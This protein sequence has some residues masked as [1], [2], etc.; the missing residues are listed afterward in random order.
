MRGCSSSAPVLFRRLQAEAKLSQGGGRF[1][2]NEAAVFGPIDLFVKRCKKLIELFT[3]IHQFSTLAQVHYTLSHCTSVH[4]VCSCPSKAQR[5]AL[6]VCIASDTCSPSV[7]HMCAGEM[8]KLKIHDHAAK[9]Y[10]QGLPST[11]S[12]LYAEHAHRGAGGADVQSLATSWRRSAASL[13]ICWTPPRPSLS[14][15][16]WSSTCTSAIWRPPSRRRPI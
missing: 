16:S 6:G 3:T 5:H 2:A 15:T 9:L 11:L 1:E 12:F 13:T 7:L 4:I 14:A 10:G 8:A